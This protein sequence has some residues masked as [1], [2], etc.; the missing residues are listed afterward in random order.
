MAAEFFKAPQDVSSLL[1][2][3]TSC[4]PPSTKLVAT[5]GPA[6]RDVDT[7]CAML[8]AGMQ[9]SASLG[10]RSIASVARPRPRATTESVLLAQN[11]T[12]AAPLVPLRPSLPPQTR[13]DR[14]LRL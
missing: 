9:V 13:T 2:S 11:L 5:L 4:V 6:C 10:D 12:R 1:E 3:E 7:L 14:A 8:E